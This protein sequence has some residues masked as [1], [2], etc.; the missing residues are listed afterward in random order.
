MGAWTRVVRVG[1]GRGFE[2][3]FAVSNHMYKAIM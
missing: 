2:R 3:W 1:E